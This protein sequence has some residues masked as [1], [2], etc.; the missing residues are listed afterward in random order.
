MVLAGT[1]VN[2]RFYAGGSGDGNWGVFVLKVVIGREARDLGFLPAADPSHRSHRA[3]RD[4]G[5]ETIMSAA[6]PTLGEASFHLGFVD[7]IKAIR[8]A[9]V[10]ALICFSHSIALPRCSKLSSR[11]RLHFAAK[12]GVSFSLGSRTRRRV[13]FLIPG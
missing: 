13:L 10:Q 6:D 5:D 12:L 4:L 3:L 9:R 1:V 11:V 8:W 7:S 2:R